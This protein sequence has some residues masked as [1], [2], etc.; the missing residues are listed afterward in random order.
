MHK[1]FS[2]V[3]DFIAT[4]ERITLFGF[5]ID[6]LRWIENWNEMCLK[7]FENP[8]GLQ[9]SLRMAGKVFFLDGLRVGFQSTNLIVAQRLIRQILYSESN[10]F[11]LSGWTIFCTIKFFI[12]TKNCFS[13]LWKEMKWSKGVDLMLPRR[14]VK[15]ESTR[16]RAN[17][18]F[19]LMGQINAN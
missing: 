5:R 6:S 18:F 16:R 19:A 2:I 14:L 1:L 4:S 7:Y 8:D 9:L 12:R 13:S 15:W 17:L 10:C 3:S 11:K